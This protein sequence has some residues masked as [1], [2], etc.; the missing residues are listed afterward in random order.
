MG[1]LSHQY[2]FINP[3]SWAH[4]TLEVKT[5]VKLKLNIPIGGIVEFSP[6]GFILGVKFGKNKN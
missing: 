2:F 5:K 6:K 3:K 4:F 1:I